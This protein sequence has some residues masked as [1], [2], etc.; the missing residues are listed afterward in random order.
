[1]DDVKGHVFMEKSECLQMQE[2]HVILTSRDI[3]SLRFKYRGGLIRILVLHFS[4]IISMRCVI[5]PCSRYPYRLVAY[6][7][8]R[9]C[10]S[11]N[12]KVS[13]LVLKIIAR[14]NY[15]ILL[16]LI[17]SLM[18]S[19]VVVPVSVASCSFAV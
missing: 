1:M 14:P 10:T 19:E 13:K 17:F 18:R 8:T 6:T 12:G 5:T 4:I 16:R 3:T 9:S 2:I 7:Y 15:E 11:G